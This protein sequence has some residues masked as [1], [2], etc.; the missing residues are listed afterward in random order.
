VVV[1]GFS[2]DRFAASA[3]RKNNSLA[4]GLFTVQT[5]EGFSAI[6]ATGGLEAILASQGEKARPSGF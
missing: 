4:P 5:I 6:D 3:L 2:L 1:D